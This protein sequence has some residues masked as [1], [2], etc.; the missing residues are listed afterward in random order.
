MLVGFQRGLKL[1]SAF[2][3]CAVASWSPPSTTVFMARTRVVLR[4]LE[5]TSLQPCLC[6]VDQSLHLLRMVLKVQ[7]LCT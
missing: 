2:V 7:A 6:D 4:Q 1:T 5:L 3:A